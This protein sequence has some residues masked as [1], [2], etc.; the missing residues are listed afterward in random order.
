MNR[1]EIMNFLSAAYFFFIYLFLSWI[2]VGC[3]RE[4]S[5]GPQNNIK[6]FLYKITNVLIF[7]SV[8]ISLG[9]T[10]YAMAEELLGIFESEWPSIEAQRCDGKIEKEIDSAKKRGF[11]CKVEVVE[12]EWETKPSKMARKVCFYNILIFLVKFIS[13]FLFVISQD[14]FIG[15]IFKF[16]LLNRQC[17]LTCV[18]KRQSNLSAFLWKH[19]RINNFQTKLLIMACI[20]I[21][22]RSC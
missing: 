13:I 9:D 19:I 20:S 5:S 12:E 3:D 4:L 17:T 22:F 7:Y 21:H 8:F 18:E 6:Q 2:D 14:S 1:N 10:A 11:G 15:Y 16:I